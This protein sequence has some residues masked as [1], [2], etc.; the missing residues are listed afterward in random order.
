MILTKKGNHDKPKNAPK[1]HGLGPTKCDLELS[2]FLSY[3]ALNLDGELPNN[4]RELVVVIHSIWD[5]SRLQA[6]VK[7]SSS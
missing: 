5:P 2:T 7:S 1:P 6:M 3:L 4:D